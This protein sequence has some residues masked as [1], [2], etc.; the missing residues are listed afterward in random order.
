MKPPFE[1]PF[2]PQSTFSYFFK[3]DNPLKTA[4]HMVKICHCRMFVLCSSLCQHTFHF[5]CVIFNGKPNIL[6][7]TKVLELN[8]LI[9]VLVWIRKT[10][11]TSFMGFCVSIMKWTCINCRCV[12]RIL[13][14]YMK[15]ISWIVSS[16]F[17][18]VKNSVAIWELRPLSMVF[19]E[20]FKCY[21]FQKSGGLEKP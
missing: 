13:H 2:S 11:L 6:N 9:I 12:C 10:K 17:F 5:L 19:L 4:L 14:T 16:F 1:F 18:L 7:S 3:G 20:T 21:P 15:G 8:K